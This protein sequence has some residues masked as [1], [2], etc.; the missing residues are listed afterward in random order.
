MN[1]RTLGTDGKVQAIRAVYVPGMSAGK[2]AA[3][4]GGVTRNAVI[5][6]YTRHWNKLV[7]CPLGGAQPKSMTPRAQ[8]AR[9][10]RAKPSPKSRP[11][12]R[13]VKPEKPIIVCAE[14]EPPL[15]ISLM[16]MERHHCRWPVTEDGPHLFCGRDR[17]DGSSYCAGHAR[18][19]V[20]RGTEGERSADRTLL[21][22]A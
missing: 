8:K 1:W 9:G 20:G 3:A 4:I 22:A 17:A 18:L 14:I 15:N 16:D 2:I 10:A 6:M 11:A 13:I 5:G 7:D 19:S 12:L 21:A